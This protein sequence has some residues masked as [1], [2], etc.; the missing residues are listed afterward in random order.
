MRGEPT[1]QRVDSTGGQGQVVPAPRL[2]CA[3]QAP[4][5]CCCPLLP[6]EPQHSGRV[7]PP[8]LAGSDLEQ[9]PSLCSFGT[10]HMLQGWQH[11]GSPGTLGFVR[12]LVHQA[13][14]IMRDLTCMI[15]ELQL[16]TTALPRGSGTS[17][18]SPLGGETGAAGIDAP[19]VCSRNAEDSS[20]PLDSGQLQSSCFERWAGF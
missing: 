6:A 19:S 9:L 7:G 2:G 4:A 16:C 20:P 5:A 1:R 11:V 10:E 13:Q 12:F 15:S 18:G 8:N 17:P 14:V 3:V